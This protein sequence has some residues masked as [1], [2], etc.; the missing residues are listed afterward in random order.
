MS[1]DNEERQLFRGENVKILDERI[2]GQGIHK[3]TLLHV[4]PKDRCVEPSWIPKTDVREI[5][6]DAQEII[7]G[8]IRH[9]KLNIKCQVKGYGNEK[10]TTDFFT[11]QNKL[12][13][14]V[15][16]PE[17]WIEDSDSAENKIHD[18]LKSLLGTLRKGGS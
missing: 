18:K 12:I 2:D 16:I 17:E 15:N 11:E 1:V 14:G 7:E 4:Q 3:K 5:R 8:A 6:A 13:K 10:Y 9:L